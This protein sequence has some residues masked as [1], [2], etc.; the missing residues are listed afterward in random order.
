MG[1]SLD[2]FPFDRLRLHPDEQAQWKALGWA[3][4]RS[5]QYALLLTDRALHLRSAIW[6]ARWRSIP[7]ALVRNALFNDSWWGPSLR[8][9]T[10]AG[11]QVL[12]TPWD[13]R[14]E[15][16]IDRENLRTA[17]A[18]VRHALAGAADVVQSHRS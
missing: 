7:L 17:A 18:R 4:H 1:V 10:T 2:E 15:M 3:A 6:F 8:V 13:V 11:N 9:E 16:D 14:V 12:R 5:T